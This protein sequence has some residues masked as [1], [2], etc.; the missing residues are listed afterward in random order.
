MDAV[1]ATTAGVPATLPPP[2]PLTRRQENFARCVASGMSYAEAFRQAG[3][4]ASTAG[5]QSR[6]IQELKREPRVQVRIA[7]LRVRADQ[8]VVSTI[9]ER[10][11]WLK[12][13]VSADPAEISRVVVVPCDLCWPE[14]EIATAFATYFTVSPF[15]EGEPRV[16]PDMTKPRHA[17]QRCHGDGFG[18]VVL[19]P[20]DELT[21]AARALF[22]GAKQNEKGVIEIAMHDQVA[23]AEMLNKLQ[24]AYVT[25]SLNL[26]ANVAVHAARDASP[27]DAMRLFDAFAPAT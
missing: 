24:S 6:Q 19:T 10:M 11:A 5:S 26:N 7:E 23:A 9:A 17:C 13:I 20:T 22:K 16:L 14:A 15:N 27:E 2:R 3:C 25:R 18:R 4:V 8:E 21:P 1:P 12:L